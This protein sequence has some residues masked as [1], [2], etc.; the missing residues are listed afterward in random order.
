MDAEDLIF[1]TF[2]IGAIVFV[3]ALFIWILAFQIP[4]EQRAASD[5]HVVVVQEYSINSPFG[6]EVD[7]RNVNNGT[8]YKAHIILPDVQIGQ[9][10]I[11]DTDY[12]NQSV[13]KIIVPHK[14][15]ICMDNC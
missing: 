13:N 6:P 10:V 11:L 8:I 9:S 12:R 1:G 2:I 4:S 14:Y 15:E 5:I 3:I 7:F